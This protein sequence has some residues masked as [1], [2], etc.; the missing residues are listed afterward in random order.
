VLAQVFDPRFLTII[1]CW[2]IASAVLDY[3]TPKDFNFLHCLATLAP[4][5]MVWAWRVWASH[6]PE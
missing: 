3:L 1:G 6:R 5:A 4:V 2:F